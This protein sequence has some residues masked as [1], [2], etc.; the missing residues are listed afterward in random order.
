[1]SAR[2]SA[3]LD[4]YIKA[5]CARSTVKGR[6]ARSNVLGETPMAPLAQRNADAFDQL[7]NRTATLYYS[8]ADAT[9]R[10]GQWEVLRTKYR[11]R[12]LAARDDYEL[13]GVLHDMLREHPAYR[14]AATG[15]AAVSS[16]SVKVMSIPAERV[17]SLASYR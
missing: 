9:A 7:W 3:Q 10:R 17:I 12:A 5:I 4:T 8:A 15:R 16:A 6:L 13:K 1:M 14:Q 11:P 2:R